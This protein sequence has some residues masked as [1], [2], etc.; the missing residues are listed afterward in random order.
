[1]MISSVIAAINCSI[2][3]YRVEPRSVVFQELEMEKDEF[4]KMMDA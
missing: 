2:L 3:V 1:M 4:E